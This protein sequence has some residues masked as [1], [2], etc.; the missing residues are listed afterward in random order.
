MDIVFAV[1]PDRVNVW[2]GLVKARG[3]FPV[4]FIMRVHH[5]HTPV[6]GMS[7]QDDL[8][9]AELIVLMSMRC[10]IIMRMLINQANRTIIVAM[11]G[12][13][14]FGGTVTIVE[15]GGNYANWAECVPVR[16]SLSSL[17]VVLMGDDTNHNVIAA[18]GMCG[19]NSKYRL[20]PSSNV[21]VSKRRVNIGHIFRPVHMS[22][23]V[24]CDF[25][26]V[27]SVFRNR[28]DL[29]S[30]IIVSRITTVRQFTVAGS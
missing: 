7:V 10:Y 2:F 1:V 28:N 23:N 6:A 5:V 19:F 8:E 14:G 29:P 30:T 18:V 22:T 12:N 11:R 15:M 4:G 13:K 3:V 16:I 20:Y 24:D 9:D 25:A 21:G 17:S 26:A 27:M